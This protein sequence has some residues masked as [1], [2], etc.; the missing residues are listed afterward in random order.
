MDWDAVKRRREARGTEQTAGWARWSPG[1]EGDPWPLR[2]EFIS[3]KHAIPGRAV[4][5]RRRRRESGPALGALAWQVLG[6]A[7]LAAAVYL[8]FHQEGETARRIREVA[9][10]A[11]TQQMVWG[12]AA[13]WF[14]EVVG[15]GLALPA[16]GTTSDPIWSAPL[17]GT[18]LQPY[19][20][21]RPWV[22]FGGVPGAAVAAAGRGIVER[23]DRQEP[24][25]LYVVI[26][27]GKRGK[28]LYGRLGDAQV[29]PGDYVYPGQAVGHLQ[30]EKSPAQLLFGYIVEGR[31]ADPRAVLEGKER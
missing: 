3:A 13:G 26:N 16:V 8:A 28:T 20:P 4:R 17:S 11:L 25:G 22:I 23:V 31:Y 6:A 15:D 9:A 2:R 10:K 14:Q 21:E 12:D 29:K 18:V 24:Y 27:H 1:S 7:V 30:G 19:S 5:Q